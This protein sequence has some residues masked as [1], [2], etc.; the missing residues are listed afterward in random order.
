MSSTG[1]DQK[2]GLEIGQDRLKEVG[3]GQEGAL[4]TP[5]KGMALVEIRNG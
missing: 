5:P 3:V 4:V 1:D 2:N